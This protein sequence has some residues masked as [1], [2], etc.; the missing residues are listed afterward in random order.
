MKIKEDSEKRDLKVGEKWMTYFDEFSD[1]DWSQLFTIEDHDLVHDLVHD[2]HLLR[3][4]SL[5]ANFH[6]HAMDPMDVLV[7]IMA[8]DV[9]SI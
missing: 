1:N 5:D 2:E 7:G 4:G 6:V 3:K 9:K 8:N